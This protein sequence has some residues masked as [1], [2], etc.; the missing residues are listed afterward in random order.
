MRESAADALAAILDDYPQQVDEV[1]K[2]LFEMYQDK[3]VV[4]LLHGG[5]KPWPGVASAWL[6]LHQRFIKT[7]AV[8]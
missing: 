1:L 5:L 8:W 6:D 7:C 3:L 2:K 4:G